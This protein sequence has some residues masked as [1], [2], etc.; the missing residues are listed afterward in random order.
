MQNTLD[1]FPDHPAPVP[2]SMMELVA[3]PGIKLTATQRAFKQLVSSI[4]A[5]ETRLREITNLIDLFRPVFSKKLR[6]LHDARDVLTREMVQFLDEQLQRKGWTANQRN[7]MREIACQLAEQLFGGAHREEMEAVFDRH[8]DIT[9]ADRAAADAAKFEAGIEELF[10][11]DPGA[12]VDG[13]RSPEELMGEALRKIDRLEQEREQQAEARAAA[14]R[15]GNKSGR[16]TKAEQQALD[17]GKLLKEIYRKLTSAIHPDRE[18]NAAERTRKTALMSAVN[19]AYESGNL[20]KLLQL[21][22]QAVKVDSRAAATLADEK[23]QLINH[24]LRRQQQELQLECRQL[25][26]VVREEFQV[27]Y[28]GALNA[29]VLQKALNAAVAGERADLKIM[30]HDLQV[31]RSS[32]SQLKNWLKE[33]RALMREDE[34][35]EDALAQAM[36]GIPRRRR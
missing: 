9:A 7:T 27:N 5:A 31:I 19:Q 3:L 29:P 1:L 30:R 34:R 26:A 2:G 25:D 12:D 28:F 24:T 16:Q 13:P 10:G 11:V 36:M 4:E 35:F 18:P 14:R 15:G 32:D 8:S 20:L 17:A 23:L 6:P 33:Q 22:L 21:Q